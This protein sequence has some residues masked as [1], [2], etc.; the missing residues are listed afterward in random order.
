MSRTRWLIVAFWVF[1]GGM[2]W[3]QFNS[4][5]TAIDVKAKEHPTQEHFF[6]NGSPNPDG[7]MPK[8]TPS[9]TNPIA[10]AADV[11]QVSYSVQKD[12]PGTGSATATI[13]LKN[14][15][16]AKAVGVEVFLRPYRAAP[17]TDVNARGISGN[18]ALSE[19]DPVSQ[20]GQW[21]TFPDLAPNESATQS[22]VFTEHQGLEPGGNPTPKIV[23]A[24][25]QAKP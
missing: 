7:S 8:P 20:M 10:P 24:T 11:E 18:G 3:W 6:A 19:D 21:V 22:V 1:I 15:G 2:L 25:E 14:Q 9:A 23:S 5:N 12:T 17:S 16:N 4:Y 13:V